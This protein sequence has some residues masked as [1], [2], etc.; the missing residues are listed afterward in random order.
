MPLS[1]KSIVTAFPI[2]FALIFI[3]SAR[4][5]D[6][7][8][9]ELVIKFRNILSNFGNDA[10]KTITLEEIVESVEQLALPIDIKDIIIEF[11]L[12]YL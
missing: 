9:K 11:K 2:L 1:E 6:L 12:K 7:N 5:S 4:F 8:F 10:F 3:S